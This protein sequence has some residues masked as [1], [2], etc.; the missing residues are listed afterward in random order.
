MGDRSLPGLLGQCK[1]KLTHRE[2]ATLYR[3][4]PPCLGRSLLSMLPIHPPHVLDQSPVRVLLSSAKCQ[5]TSL[6]ITDH[7]ELRPRSRRGTAKPIPG[8]CSHQTITTPTTPGSASPSRWVMRPSRTL[9]SND[10]KCRPLELEFRAHVLR[11]PR[12]LV[13]MENSITPRTS[14]SA[15]WS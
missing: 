7:P 11:G 4:S 6:D 5:V 9:F 10:I 12:E 14:Y 3:V 13:L 2:A 1:I 8:A 15:E